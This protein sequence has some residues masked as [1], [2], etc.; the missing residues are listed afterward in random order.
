MKLIIT[1]EQFKMILENETIKNLEDYKKG[2]NGFFGY[3]IG[4]KDP[5]P[6]EL[7]SKIS[8]IDGYLDL[9]YSKVTQLP[10]NLRVDG[11]IAL[12]NTKIETLPSGLEVEGDLS[13]IN[14]RKLVD[15]PNDIIVKGNLVLNG[16]KFD[17]KELTKSLPFVS[18]IILMT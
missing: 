8:Y 6:D 1:E 7:L 12:D 17:K 11:Y 4:K 18:N 14:C 10:K 2:K 3:K 5:N 9:S 16:K 13:L 15:I